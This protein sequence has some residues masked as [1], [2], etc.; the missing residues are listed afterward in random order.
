MSDPTHRLDRL[1]HVALT[2]DDIAATV[3]W[4][5]ERFDCEVRY[6]DE[7]WA[8]IHFDNVDLAFVNP[9]QHPSH[10]GFVHQR[11]EDFGELKPHRDG[12]KSLYL[13][14]AAGNAV[15]LLSPEGIED[16][17]R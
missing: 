3:R 5:V 1:H 7:T 14:D 16:G 13:E 11:A 17:G 12:T 15:E 9:D 2:A 6:Q 8:L 10:I 4:Y